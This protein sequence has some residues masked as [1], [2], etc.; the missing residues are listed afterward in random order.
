MFIEPF[1]KVFG[2][3]NMIGRKIVLVTILLLTISYSGGC[4]GGKGKHGLS[5]SEDL[6]ATIG[7][8]V[9]VIVTESTPVEGFGLVVGLEGTGSAE[10]PPQIRAYLK[11]YILRQLP[12]RTRLDVDEFINSPETAVVSVQ[13]VIP[14]IASKNEYFDIRVTALPSTQTTSLDGGRLFT[15]ELKIPGRF[16]V[17]TRVT[18]DAEGPVYIDKIDNSQTDKK[19]GYVLAGGKVLGDYKVFLMLHKLDFEMANRIRNRINGR[20]SEAAAKAVSSERLEFIVPPKYKEQKQRFISIVVSMYLNPDP[21]INSE[22]ISAYVKRLS[23]SPDK[24]SSE[25]ALEAIGNQCLKEL[26]ALLKSSDEKTRFHAARCMLNL[27]SDAGLTALRR[28]AQDKDSAFRLEALESITFGAKR[29]DA[30]SISRKLLRDDDVRI[31]LAAYEQLRKLD[32]V[33]MAQEFVGRSFYLEQVTQTGPRTVFVSRSGQPCFVLLG[34]PISCGGNIFVQ[35]EKG[36]VII[37]A[38][39]GQTYV[40]IIRKHPKRPSEITQLKSSFDIG[41]IIRTLCNEPA[42][43]GQKGRGGLGVTYA[44]AAALLKQMCDMGVV[45]AEFHAGPMPKIGLNIK[46]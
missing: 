32:D 2:C 42:Q 40:N 25:V 34:A 46:K 45:K 19:T 12:A 33:S 20:F 9:R 6:G 35:S 11:Q 37:N 28:L 18:A 22:R 5:G 8:L 41:D 21:A 31:R 4:S 10:C 1:C 24:Y 39:T 29:N 3:M 43:E 36:D 15:A 44:D 7:S 17:N 14:A 23:D 13:G 16:G 30:I 27:G 38:P 26:G